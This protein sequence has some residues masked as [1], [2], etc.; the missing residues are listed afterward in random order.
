M[1]L[2][3]LS[4]VL[5]SFLGGDAEDKKRLEGRCHCC[6]NHFVAVAALITITGD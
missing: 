3:G 2:K 1:G 5:G 6:H 4:L